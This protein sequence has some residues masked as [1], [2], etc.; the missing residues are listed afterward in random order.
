MFNVKCVTLADL[1]LEMGGGVSRKV[2]LPLWA[3]VWSNNKGGRLVPPRA[4]PLDPPLCQNN[5]PEIVKI[6]HLKLCLMY[7]RLSVSC[8]SYVDF[9][10]C[11]DLE[12]LAM[13]TVQII[14]VVTC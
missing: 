10:S 6:I 14:Y 2:F 13:L 8:S 9:S 4:P 12:N 3:S 5:S 11:I 7:L 1:D